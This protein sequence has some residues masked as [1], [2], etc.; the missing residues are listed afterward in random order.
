MHRAVT[1]VVGPVHAGIIE[2]GRFTFSSGGESVAHLDVRLGYSHRGVE[3]FLTGRDA[4]A[5]APKLA[6]ICGACS[7]ARSWAYARALEGLAHVECDETSEY[8]RLIFA[9]LER[10][11]NHLFDLGSACAA[12]GY[13]R[14]QMAGLHLKERVHRINAEHGGHRFLFDVVVPGGVR[15]G[16]LAQPSRLAAE[17]HALR[18]EFERFAA[19]L[20]ANVSLLRRWSQTGALSELQA[21]RLDLVGPSARASGGTVDVRQDAPYGA[22]AASA[23]NVARAHV[24]DVEARC[25]VKYA[26]L[27]ESF[28]LIDA[29]LRALGTHAPGP[30]QAI[31]MQAGRT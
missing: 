13:A 5:C 7:V 27:V 9:E 3:E 19:E 30:S 26:E 18:S 11:Y 4:I 8:A 23:P 17:L 24:G 29:A 21:Q 12:A 15:A 10:A 22:Y 6:R 14:G 1:I 20:F 25:R 28:A 16:A 2:P 31:V